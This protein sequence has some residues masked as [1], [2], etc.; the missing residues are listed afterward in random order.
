M[1]HIAKHGYEVHPCWLGQLR[2][3]AAASLQTEFDS[4]CPHGRLARAQLGKQ[5]AGLGYRTPATTDLPSKTK[6]KQ[7]PGCCKVSRANQACSTQTQ[8]PRL[9][10]S[11]EFSVSSA[12][13]S[14]ITPPVSHL[15]CQ[16]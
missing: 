11:K 4:S 9:K 14:L 5:Q 2:L 6:L 3:H 13:H 7:S 15:G 8:Q 1:D 10:V 16:I 12:A